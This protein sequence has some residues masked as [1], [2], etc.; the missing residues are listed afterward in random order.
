VDCAGEKGL[1]RQPGRPYP[2]EYFMPA[3][4]TPEEKVSLPKKVTNQPSRHRSVS[5]CRADMP[6]LT[7]D[8]PSANN[9]KKAGS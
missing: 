9:D 7:F 3:A 6:K 2:D 1:A 8:T 5:H 4:W